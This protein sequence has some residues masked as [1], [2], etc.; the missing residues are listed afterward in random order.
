[1]KKSKTESSAHTPM[2]QQFNALKK[3][4]PDC[5]LFFRAGDFYE[6]FGEDAI[7][8]S[9]ALNIALT[10]RNK[11]SDNPVPMA[12]ATSWPTRAGSVSPFSVSG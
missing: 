4:H 5:I 10:V 8:A 1:M 9:E 12:G 7:K 6:M 3:A 11:A 2:M